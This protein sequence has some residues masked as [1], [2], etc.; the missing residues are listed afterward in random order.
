VPDQTEEVDLTLGIFCFI[1]MNAIGFN[2]K[3]PKKAFLVKQKL[4]TLKHHFCRKIKSNRR[5]KSI[6]TLERFLFICPHR[7]VNLLKK[8]NEGV[9]WSFDFLLLSYSFIDYL[10]NHLLRIPRL[11]DV[12]EIILPV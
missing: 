10:H 3:R 4:K 1:R 7:V 5:S 6:V 12:K 9:L 8:S 11:N 2:L